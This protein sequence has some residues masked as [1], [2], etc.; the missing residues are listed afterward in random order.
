[1]PLRL[2]GIVVLTLAAAVGVACRESE[3]DDRYN[4]GFDEG[5][6]TLLPTAGT[7]HQATDERILQGQQR[8][9]IVLREDFLA[10]TVP[11]PAEDTPADAGPP[12]SVAEALGNVGK[13][14]L[15]TLKG[16]PAPSIPAGPDAT[17][18]A[19][20]P[21]AATGADEAAAGLPAADAAAIQLVVDKLNEAHVARN[22][23]DIATLCVA[24]QRV[25]ARSLFKLRVE[26]AG[27]VNLLV[28]STETTNPSLKSAADKLWADVLVPYTLTGLT[29]AA[30][31]SAAGTLQR[32]DGSGQLAVTFERADGEW[33]L[34]HPQ[35]PTR[36][37]WPSIQ[38]ALQDA[39]DELDELTETTAI[40]GKV[41]E[42][43]ARQAI[44]TGIRLVVE[45]PTS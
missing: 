13:A 11:V 20:T 32:A 39:I 28:T 10:G 18:S 31:D 43:K 2:V 45:A 37:D 33:F 26:L 7:M 38:T 1:M 34:V 4:R 14:F 8:A 21:P 40:E 12:A 25:M 42:S 23:E 22:F 24:G 29:S 6:R 16:E 30:P 3:P 17:A 5:G 35:V 44:E 9:T 36:D 41:D 15:G 19:D 27:S